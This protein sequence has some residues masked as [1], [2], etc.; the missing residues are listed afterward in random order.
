MDSCWCEFIRKKKE[1]T[2]LLESGKCL[3]AFVFLQ[4]DENISKRK[5]EDQWADRHAERPSLIRDL[6]TSETQIQMNMPWD[7]YFEMKF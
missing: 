6:P 2:E 5:R 4:G 7:L 1:R 3:F